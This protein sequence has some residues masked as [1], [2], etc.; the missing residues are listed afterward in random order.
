MN[1]STFWCHSS[2]YNVCS[3]V[4]CLLFSLEVCSFVFL[5]FKQLEPP[6]I[7]YRNQTW[8]ICN[9]DL[10]CVFVCSLQKAFRTGTSTRL[11]ERVFAMYQ[12]K[13][14]PLAFAM[15]MIHPALYRLDDLSDEVR[16]RKPEPSL[17]GCV[18]LFSPGFPSS[19]GSAEHQRADHPPAQSPAAVGGEAQQGGSVPHGRWAG[20]FGGKGNVP[21]NKVKTVTLVSLIQVMYLWIGRNCHQNFLSQ[22]LGVSSYA[23]VPEKL[24]GKTLQRNV[25]IMNLHLIRTAAGL[26]HCKNTNITM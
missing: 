23:A 7:C 12:L 25:K 16:L 18:S 17:T 24:V 8:L 6:E 19:S 10:F 21:V 1:Q 5:W 11:D 3:F 15:L 4:D 2:K 26:L 14:Q 9:I 20:A 13:Y 22:V